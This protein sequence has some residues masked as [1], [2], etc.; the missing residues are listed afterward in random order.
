ME[1]QLCSDHFEAEDARKLK[2]IHLTMMG[3]NIDTAPE[4]SPTAKL[5]STPPHTS[6]KN[7]SAFGMG[8]T[9]NDS[10]LC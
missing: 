10:N 3:L 5:P 9:L 6:R 1:Q 7:V 8:V 4:V 2:N